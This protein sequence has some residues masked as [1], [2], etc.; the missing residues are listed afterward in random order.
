[1]IVS[2][3]H[4]FIFIKTR[5][6][7]GSSIEAALYPYLGGTDICTGSIVDGT[8]RLNCSPSITGHISWRAIRDIIGKEKYECYTKFCVERN[9]YDKAVSD[10]LYH[11]DVRKNIAASC[12]L[13]Y[14]LQYR[15]PT[16]WLRYTEN[17]IP[18]CDVLFFGNIEEEFQKHCY[19]ELNLP[20]LALICLKA[21]PNRNHYST[22]YDDTTKVLAAR[23]FSNEIHHFG[24]KFDYE[25]GYRNT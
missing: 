22:Y 25:L 16:D 11:R 17:N 23:L 18:V 13:F 24:Y 6:T 9:S 12:P 14:H 7:A 3:K 4:R 21:N 15:A 8:P 20:K 10:W 2:H 5:R 1:M 19:Y